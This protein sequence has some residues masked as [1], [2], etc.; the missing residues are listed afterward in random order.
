M[1][2]K[3]VSHNNDLK[4]LVDQGFAV[5]FD[6]NCL[7]VRDIPYLDDKNTLKMGSIVAKLVFIDQV[8]VQQDDHQVYFA[9][10]KPHG[11]NG[12]PIQNLGGGPAKIPLSSAC[13][14][15]VVERSF[16]NKPKDTNKFSDFFHKIESYVN[17]I[18]GPAMELYN[19]SPYTFRVIEDVA[20]DS[21]FKFH[22]TLTSRAEIKD[23]NDLFKDDEIAI[24]GL[25]GTG[26]YLLDMLVTCP[27]KDIR[28]FDGDMYHV[29]TAFRSAGKLD[30][31]E[32]GQLKA[33]VYQ[34]RYENFRHNI[35]LHARYI[36]KDSHADFKG[37]TFAF[38]CIDKGSARAEIFQLL[39]EIGIPFIDVGMG[40]NRKHH[41]IGGMCR[42]T[43]YSKDNAEHQLTKKRAPLID[44]PDDIYKTNIQ[45]GELN[46]INAALAVIKFKQI[47]GFYTDD[48]D[49]SHLL[50]E[51]GD[52]SILGEE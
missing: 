2:Q 48:A 27:V 24:I 47:R 6:S 37:V 21:V 46:A 44:N 36:D 1:Y 15:V 38:V 29:H 42:L 34:T 35:H 3:L 23:L 45:I 10:G 30:E 22:D 41:A 51:I 16:S 43:Y 52:M 18:S 39:T 20:V 33:N 11:I 19:V 31:K 12:H 13:Q 28:G 50:F 5:G 26:S 49:M 17:I 25:G 14:D 9:G 7:I 4:R 40:L 8:R 32:L